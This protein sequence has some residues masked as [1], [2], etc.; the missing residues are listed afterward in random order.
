M[1]SMLDSMAFRWEGA[2]MSRV[3]IILAGALLAAGCDHAP[4]LAPIAPPPPRQIPVGPAIY[5]C[6]G[7]SPYEPPVEKAIF[8]FRVAGTDGPSMA[9]RQ[10]ILKAEGIIL[11]E[12]HVP[13]IRALIRVRAVLS[14]HMGPDHTSFSARQVQPGDGTEV[15]TV[16]GIP[17]PLSAEDRGFLESRDV[18]ILREY[19]QIGAI[20]AIAPDEVI[21]AIRSHDT[22]RFVDV[23]RLA[24]PAD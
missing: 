17:A 15:E 16:I 22:V 9:A 10:A 1:F 12:Y 24:C 8:D 23:I 5:G 19:P 21:P 3:A 4:P 6:E 14:L 18:K 7:W 13:M 2:A 20:K 11:H